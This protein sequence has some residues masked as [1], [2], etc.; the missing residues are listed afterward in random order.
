[1]LS[2]VVCYCFIA[3]RMYCILLLAVVNLSLE[4]D[5]HLST[6]ITGTMLLEFFFSLQYVYLFL[7]FLFWFSLFY[8]A[9]N[10]LPF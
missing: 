7:E 10:I 8:F 3:D 6:T 5:I 9:I 1:M 4:S 2:L